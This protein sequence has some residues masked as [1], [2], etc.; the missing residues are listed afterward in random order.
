LILRAAMPLL[1]LAFFS[2][3]VMAGIRFATDRQSPP[4][5]AKLHGYAA[6]AALALLSYGWASL[7]LSQAASFGVLALV[8]AAVGGVVLNLHYHW[9]QRPLP[10]WLVFAHM[11]VAF[12]GTLFVGMA[13]LSQP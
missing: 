12:I 1:A 10:E 7:A 5:L 3:L 6:I 13:A 8:I 11:S 2:G 4:W 9:K